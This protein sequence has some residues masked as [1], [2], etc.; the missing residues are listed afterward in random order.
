[1][2]EE[3]EAEDPSAA[4]RPRP[5]RTLLSALLVFFVFVLATAALKGWRDL[6]TTHAR[7]RALRQGVQATEARISDLKRRIERLRHDP[8][9][10]DR[11]ARGQLGLVRPDDVVIVLEPGSGDSPGATP[12]PP[13]PAPAPN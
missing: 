10:L 11:E 5:W 4:P 3:P 7:E 6:E 8:I 13:A 1:M 12:A 2:S 9:A